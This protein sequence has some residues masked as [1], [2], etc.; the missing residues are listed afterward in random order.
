MG[1]RASRRQP[2]PHR[3]DPGPPGRPPGQLDNDYYR[4]GEALRDIE[5]EYG[6]DGGGP[7]RPDRRPAGRPGP[8]QRRRP[9][10]GARAAPGHAA[11]PRGRPPRPGPGPS[12]SSSPPWP[13]AA[14]GSGCGTAAHNP[15]EVTGYA[16]SLAGDADRGRG[17]ALVRRREAGPGPDLAQAA[18][19]LARAG[20][21]GRTAGPTPARRPRGPAARARDDR[22][23]GP[24]R[25]APGG[26]PVRGR[27]PVRAGVLRRPGDGRAAGPA[28]LQPDP[29]RR[30][31]RVRGQPARHDHTGTASRSGTAARPWTGQLS[32]GALRRRWRAG[33]P[34]APPAP[35][36]FAGAEAGDIFGYAAAVA[37]EAARQLRG[38]ARPGARP[39]T[40]P[41]PPPTCSPRP[42]R[43]PAARNCSGP[44]TVSAGPPARRGAGSRRRRRPA[45]GCAPPRTCWPPAPRPGT[46]RSIARM[47]LFTALAGLAGAVADLRDGAAPAAAGLRGS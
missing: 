29:A 2:H 9:G 41:G 24:G 8:R 36:A 26:G 27:R 30:G 40:S 17:P 42:P 16:V 15:G 11:P 19:P 32:L 3:G 22:R 12:R 14:S 43:P 45:P 23:G 44:P 35:E 21:R 25:P 18:A 34:G 46:R 20:P 31:G 1:R 10:P 7:G 13:G 6:L 39:P 33:R 28:A 37:T 5:A 4:I 47:A 38:R